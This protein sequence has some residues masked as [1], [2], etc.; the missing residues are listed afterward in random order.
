MQFWCAASGAAWTWTWRAYPGVWIFIAL[1]A[2][3]VVKWNRA[4]ARQAGTTPP[5]LHPLFFLG[6]LVIWLHW[7]TT[8][9]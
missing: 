7:R 4:G 8:V 2:L 9:F 6:L 5:S 3:L 1:L